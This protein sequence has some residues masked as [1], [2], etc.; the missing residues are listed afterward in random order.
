M[1][2]TEP[3][4]DYDDDVRRLPRDVETALQTA[5]AELPTDVHVDDVLDCL[6][7]MLPIAV[8]EQHELQLLNRIYAIRGDE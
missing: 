4:H 6:C 7:S 2:H 3:T 5:L 8:V 1:T